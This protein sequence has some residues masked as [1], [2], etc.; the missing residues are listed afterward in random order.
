MKLEITTN[1]VVC[2]KKSHGV[3]HF[4]DTSSGWEVTDSD[5][6]ILFENGWTCCHCLGEPYLS[7]DFTVDFLEER[8]KIQGIT[9][10]D[11]DED[12]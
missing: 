8:N 11:D 2:E 10:E 7:S 9:L 5:G 12:V 6:G 1:C 3:L 4:S